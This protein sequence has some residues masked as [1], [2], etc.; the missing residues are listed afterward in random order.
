MVAEAKFP[1]PYRVDSSI[2]PPGTTR[3][4]RPWVDANLEDV[5]AVAPIQ[6]VR[7][8]VA[9]TRTTDTLDVIIHPIRRTPEEVRTVEAQASKHVT[10]VWRRRQ[11]IN[12]SATIVANA[13]L[14]MP[15]MIAAHCDQ[16]RA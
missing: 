5:V 1:R 14:T 8:T 7:Q 15:T 13:R 2:D 16:R 3:L 9:I 11:G 10:G 6:L 4:N 12:L